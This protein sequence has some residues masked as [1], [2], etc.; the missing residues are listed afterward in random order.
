MNH[1]GIILAGGS[2]SRR[3]PEHRQ[4]LKFACP[5]EIAH[6]KGFI[7]AGQLETL[8]QPLVKNGCARYL[9]HLLKKWAQS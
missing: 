2:G 9:Q 5:E 1:Q 6:R 3:Y 4:G 8:A 7:N